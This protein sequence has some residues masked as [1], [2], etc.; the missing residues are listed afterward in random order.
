MNDKTYQNLVLDYLKDEIYLNRETDIY[1]PLYETL[2]E[3]KNNNSINLC[4]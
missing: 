3:I 1:M 4:R 2:V